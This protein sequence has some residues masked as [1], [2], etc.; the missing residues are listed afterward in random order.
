MKILPDIKLD[1]A[2]VL[3]RPKRSELGSRSEVGLERQFTFR[4]SKKSWNG[5][6]IIVSNMDTSGTI[7]MYRVLSKYK[8]ITC[9]HKF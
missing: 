6:P 2:D 9:L 3:I 5:I 8:I 4:Y 1:F 7:E